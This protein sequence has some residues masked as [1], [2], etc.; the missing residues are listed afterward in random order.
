MGK[1]YFHKI[2]FENIKKKEKYPNF[3]NI[4]QEYKNF[5]LN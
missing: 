4:G 5:D 2:I 3:G 1:Y